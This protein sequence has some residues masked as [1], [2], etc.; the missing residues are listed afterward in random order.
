MLE[1]DSK[2]FP[3]APPSSLDDVQVLRE[4]DWAA[5]RSIGRMSDHWDRPGWSPGHRAYYW[6]L[7]PSGASGLAAEALAC[8]EA[9]AELGMDPVPPEGLHV[10]MVKIG[11]RDQVTEI[12]LDVLA[13]SVRGALGAPFRVAAYP[14]TGSR[15]AIRFTL[16]PWRNLVAVHAVLTQAGVRAGVPGGRPTAGFRPH[17]GVLYNNRDRDAAAPV[18]AV[19]ALR[20]R[21]PVEFMVDAVQLVELRREARTYRWDTVREIALGGPDRR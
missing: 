10:T 18:Q 1:T 2:A 8:Q 12:Q 11:N 17:L 4:A 9:L 3:P 6:M 20:G 7:A 21:G 16:A 15:G 14:M 5:F 13:A 19:G